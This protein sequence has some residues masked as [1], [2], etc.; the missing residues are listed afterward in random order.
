MYGE[1]PT[2]PVVFA[3]CDSKY[4][5]EHAAPLIYSASEVGKKDVHV[6]IVNPTDEAISLAGVL[7]ATTKQRVTY[8]YNDMEFPD[9]TPE[10]I[11]AYY[12]SLRF[13]VA[14]HIL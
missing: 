11:R 5:L 12:A 7:N 6:H 14:P 10:M 4:F 3:A 2:S 9:W 1:M 13:L 8:T